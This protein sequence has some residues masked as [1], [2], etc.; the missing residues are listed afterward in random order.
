MRTPASSATGTTS[1]T[2]ELKVSHICSSEN[3]SPNASLSFQAGPSNTVTRVPPRP[4][5]APK[6]VRPT[7]PGIQFRPST[8]MPAAPML[9]TVC[10]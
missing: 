8:P 2:N 4:T 6:S 3:V 9:R 7:P 10:W 1:S 5:A